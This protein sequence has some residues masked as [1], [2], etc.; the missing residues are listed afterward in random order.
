MKASIIPCSRSSARKCVPNEETLLP[1]YFEPSTSIEYLCLAR[2]MLRAAAGHTAS[3]PNVAMLKL[4][5]VQRL[6]STSN[7]SCHSEP[8]PD[9]L[10]LCWELWTRTTRFKKKEPE[11]IATSVYKSIFCSLFL[12]MTNS[13]FSF[14]TAL[15]HSQTYHKSRFCFSVAIVSS[16][17]KNLYTKLGLLSIFFYNDTILDLSFEKSCLQFFII[18][19]LLNNLTYP[20]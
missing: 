8:Y 20:K 14:L 5:L 6:P 3:F 18:A 9:S 17:P 2:Q 1:V 7:F 19:T 4:L 10:Y 13:R 11:N 12:M 16:N 15:E